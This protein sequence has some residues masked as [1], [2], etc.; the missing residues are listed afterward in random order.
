MDRPFAHRWLTPLFG[1][2]VIGYRAALIG[3]L[4]C[5]STF[6]AGC[7]QSQVETIWDTVN[8]SETASTE[9]SELS[10]E[11][12]ASPSPNVSAPTS[13]SAPET[14]IAPGQSRDVKLSAGFSITPPE[15]FNVIYQNEGSDFQSSYEEYRW[16]RQSGGVW[17]IVTFH[18]GLA[19]EGARKPNIREERFALERIQPAFARVDE[20]HQ[21]RSNGSQPESL[22]GLSAIR[23]NVY[24]KVKGKDAIGHLY[25]LFDGT[26]LIEIVA[27]ATE[28]NRSV[29][30]ACRESASSLSH[31]DG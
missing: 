26:H 4:V 30:K 31:A 16:E 13:S 12:A 7:T 15:T 23:T 6:F 8:T 2:R 20:K 17:F 19:Y 1:Y 11:P 3:W 5:G 27:L 25:L 9:T 14:Y 22:G 29:L 28:S 18:S 10:D 21:L 24:G